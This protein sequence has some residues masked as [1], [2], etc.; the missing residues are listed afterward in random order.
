MFILG[1]ISFLQVTFLPGFLLLQILGF[2]GKRKLQLLIYSFALSLL[3][4]YLVVYLLTLLGLYRPISIYL[5]MVLELGLLF[6]YVFLKM[7]HAY[8]SYEKI[9]DI[10]VS[11]GSMFRSFFRE[12]PLFFIL[13]LI[14]MVMIFVYASYIFQF[15]G[16]I[17]TTQESGIT[18]NR[19]ALDWYN[20]Q[21][22]VLSWHY[23][24]LIPANWSIT[25]IV[26]Q[27][28]S[29]QMFN[30][31]IMALFPVMIL[32]TFLDLALVKKNIMYLLGLYFY[33]NILGHFYHPVFVVSG[34]VDI[35]VSFFAFLVFSTLISPAKEYKKNVIGLFLPLLFAC[36]AAVTKQSGI[37]VL[38]VALIWF[39]KQ[40][41]ASLYL[42]MEL[43]T[44]AVVF[45]LLAILLSWYMLKEV[46]VIRGIDHSEFSFI[47]KGIWSGQGYLHRLTN[48]FNGLLLSW[49]DSSQGSLFLFTVL[50]LLICSLFNKTGRWLFILILPYMLLWGVFLSYDIRNLIP[51]FPFIALSS[52]LG[53]IC[54]F[55][56]L[57]KSRIKLS[58]WNTYIGVGV[59]MVLLGF[60]AFYFK[61]INGLLLRIY[62]IVGLGKGATVQAM[63]SQAFAWVTLMVGSLICISL[64]M[65]RPGFYG[66][67]KRYRLKLIYSILVFV[68]FFW[69]LN[70][71]MFNKMTLINEQVR[72]QRE[73]GKRRMNRKLYDYHQKFGFEG[74][75]LT[76][77]QY[78]RYLPEIGQYSRLFQHRVNLRNLSRIKKTDKINYLLL[79]KGKISRE[80]KE[81]IKNHEFSLIFTFE[82]FNFIGLE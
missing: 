22:P 15:T 46:Q 71:M 63:R 57:S 36:A 62:S 21:V 66:F 26:I 80:I 41:K 31:A 81:K 4:N 18:W 72:L 25:Y 56:V 5:L 39:L 14:S 69:V 28:S 82:E 7:G 34:E 47:T 42:K 48:A 45:T 59:I 49:G 11:K 33:G 44:V 19:W 58:P 77:Y 67:L 37:Y 64:P 53:L 2:A 17:F 40:K 52:S 51:V 50:F 68:P 65:C 76:D 23:P 61:G 16:S 12:N 43:K 8:I 10:F 38:L 75:I 79:S 73:I 6:Y 74:K 1:L 29:I 55:K 20:N 3:F 27:N 70:S 24:Q 13:Y 78:L 32:L 54:V 9:K 60:A 35:A 30:K